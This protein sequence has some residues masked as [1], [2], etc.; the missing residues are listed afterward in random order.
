MT[1]QNR[2]ELK[3]GKFGWYYYD[4]TIQIDMT[5]NMTLSRLNRSENEITLMRKTITKHQN[6]INNLKNK[7]TILDSIDTFTFKHPKEVN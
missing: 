6:Q 3:S 4:N 1:S 7:L 2:Y 5:L